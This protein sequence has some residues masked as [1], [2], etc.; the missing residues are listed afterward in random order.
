MKRPLVSHLQVWILDSCTEHSPESCRI[1]TKNVVDCFEKCSCISLIPRLSPKRC[2]SIK[3]LRVD[4]SSLFD[5][6]SIRDSETLHQRRFKRLWELDVSIK[7]QVQGAWVIRSGHECKVQ[8][9]SFSRKRRKCSSAVSLSSLRYLR[10][11]RKEAICKLRFVCGR[12]V[13]FADLIPVDQQLATEAS[14]FGG[15]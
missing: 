15:A 4:L 1:A 9:W 7:L 3:G 8:F 13:Q 10:C 11:M 14:W 5:S 6:C 12:C 2:S